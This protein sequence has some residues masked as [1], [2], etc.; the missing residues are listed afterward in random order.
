M[1][2]MAM[3]IG[4]KPEKVEEYKRLHANAWPE[5]LDMISKC[6]ITNYSI[7]LKEPEN[8][9]FGYWEYT[10]EDF[11][12]DAAK[13]AA[14]PKTQEWWDVCMPCQVPLDTRKEGEWW[15]MMEEVF[16]HD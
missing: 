3:V 4:L 2:R 6:N 11:E 5:I 12:A 14:D 10:G 1:Q 13:M 15:S 8:L 7:F 9:L 16:H